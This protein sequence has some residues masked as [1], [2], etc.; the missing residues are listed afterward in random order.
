MVNHFVGHGC[1]GFEVWRAGAYDGRASCWS[2]EGQ[3]ISISNIQS[4]G[5]R[6]GGSSR[7]MV[8]DGLETYDAI[9]ALV[10]R[11]WTLGMVIDNDR[12]LMKSSRTTRQL[13]RCIM[14]YALNADRREARVLELD[15]RCHL[16]SATQ[17]RALVPRTQRICD[18]GIYHAV[19]RLVRP[20]YEGPQ[21]ASPPEMDAMRHVWATNLSLFHMLWFRRVLLVLCPRRSRKAMT[22]ARDCEMINMTSAWS[23]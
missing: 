14:T 4:G 19:V 13:A 10:D 15:E 17:T 8:M 11:A 2:N 5:G 18:I 20:A 1:E 21:M 9:D 23:P 3:A 6:D 12:S 22:P 7:V 16:T